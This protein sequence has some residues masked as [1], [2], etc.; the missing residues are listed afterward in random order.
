MNR[1]EMLRTLA[2]GV[3]ATLMGAAARARAA[4]TAE[5]CGLGVC[6]YCLGIRNRFER[7]RGRTDF[8][9]PLRFLEHCH[10]LGAGG[11]QTPLGVRDAEYAEGL[12]RRAEQLGMF[13]EG[14]AGLPHQPGAVEQFDAQI[15]TARAAGA[16]AV[17]VVMMP[18]RRYERFDS[19][20]EFREFAERGRKA[21]E[22]AE[23]VAAKH[24]LPLA[25]ENHKDHRVPERLDV[26]ERLSS[27]YVGTCVDTGN[28]FALCEDPLAVVEAYAPRAFSVHLKDQG[29]REY[30]EGFLFGDVPLGQGFLDLPKMVEVLRKAKPDVCFTLEMITRDPLRVP[31]LTEK[32]WATMAD[33][34]GRDL[35]RTL[36]T[37][38]ANSAAEPLPRISDLAH[39]RQVAREQ[40][41]VRECLAYAREH[42]GL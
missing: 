36:R 24:K 8:F 10:E 2:G 41:N 29:V 7:E 25:V 13:I 6:I 40:S 34:P 31:C 14:I 18:G 39:D 28:S 15:R 21:L 4:E 20:E 17:R 35:A 12:R 26:L 1:R 5:R 32:Y 33:V 38:R 3:S 16:R 23:P 37:V 27:E 42:L 30:D 19:T 11:I 22:L 9:E